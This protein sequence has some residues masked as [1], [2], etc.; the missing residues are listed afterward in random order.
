MHPDPL[1]RTV[2][3]GAGT[4]SCLHGFPYSL[5]YP[6]SVTEHSII[7]YTIRISACA[8][9]LEYHTRLHESHIPE[10][11]LLT[12]SKESFFACPAAHNSR[13]GSLQSRSTTLDMYLHISRRII[14]IKLSYTPPFSVNHNYTSFFLLLSLSPN[15]YSQFICNLFV[16][17]LSIFTIV[18]MIIIVLI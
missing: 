14:I 7:N 2:E 1:V 9:C 13:T 10:S 5:I 4:D 3:L 18:V 17:F 6:Q 11:L 8:G 16:F 12:R 15:S